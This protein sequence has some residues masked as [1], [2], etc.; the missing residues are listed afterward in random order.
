MAVDLRPFIQAMSEGLNR[1]AGQIRDLLDRGGLEPGVAEQ[2]H[3]LERMLAEAGYAADPP[4]QRSHSRGM[5]GDPC[6]GLPVRGPC[7]IG[8]WGG[9]DE[10][11]RAHL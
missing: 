11:D 10:F 9:L 7:R 4:P 6:G 8:G 5:A 1:A 3:E 2:L